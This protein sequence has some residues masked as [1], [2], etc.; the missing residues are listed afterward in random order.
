TP[1]WR[2]MSGISAAI[3]AIVILA[4]AGIAH[5]GSPN[6]NSNS[7]GYTIS[8]NTPGFV[9][10]AT[11][12]GALDP[13]QTMAVTV[14]LKLHNTNQLDQLVQQQHSRGNS[15]YHNWIDQTTFNATYAP[16]AQEVNSFENFA[17]GHKLSVLSVSDDNA[18]V[19]VSGAVGDIEKA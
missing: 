12:T 6:A 18:F 1:R 14:W 16:T 2:L 9:K 4:V 3:V 19:K 7:N 5:A 8:N 13:T 15:N 17:Q 10:H 11:D